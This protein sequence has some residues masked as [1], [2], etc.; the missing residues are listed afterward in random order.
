MFVHREDGISSTE[1]ILTRP[2]A[3]SA[4]VVD[5]S[6]SGSSMNTRYDEAAS[7]LPDIRK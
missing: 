4:S 3:A 2:V 1:Y 6:S 7:P 5:A